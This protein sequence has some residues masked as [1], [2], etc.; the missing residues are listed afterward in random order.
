MINL[1]INK[2]ETNRGNCKVCK[3]GTSRYR[4]KL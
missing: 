3:K 2:G 1:I 4:D